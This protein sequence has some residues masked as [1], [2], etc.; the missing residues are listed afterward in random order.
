MDKKTIKA[1]DE[2]ASQYVE[3]S[4]DTILQY[5]LTQFSS[6]LR[7]KKI[8]DVGAGSG[9]DSSYLKDEGYTVSSI[10]ISEGIISSAKKKTKVNIK[11]M[12]M[13]KLDFK[14]N[15]FDGVWCCASL[16]HLSKSDA[17]K[18]VAEFFRVL[19][20]GGVLYVGLKEGDKEGY[21]FHPVLNNSKVF[22]AYYS[23]EELEELIRESNFEL[24]NSYV[25]GGTEGIS[26]INSFARKE[27]ISE[28]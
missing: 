16:L 3:N 12:D 1:Y 7:G 18:A 27:D 10:D 5:Q 23:L 17:K 21:E 22:V 24:I 14:D 25:E 6:F 15:F 28:K 20:P 26:W 4:F 19:K 13:L 2:Y 8:L 9:R 11:K